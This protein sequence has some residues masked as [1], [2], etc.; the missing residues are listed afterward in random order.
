[1]VLSAL[2]TV[3]VALVS[4]IFWYV[5]AVGY[6]VKE[7]WDSYGYFVTYPASLGLSALTGYYA[8]G[9]PWR[10]GLIVT[11]AQLPVMMM[12]EPTVGPLIGAGILILAVLSLPAVAATAAGSNYKHPCEDD[13]V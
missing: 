8:P 11:F 10:W 2:R 6:G 7:P 4:V 13:A 9:S 5:A 3:L 12:L 1:M